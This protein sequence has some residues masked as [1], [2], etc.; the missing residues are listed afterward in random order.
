MDWLYQDLA[1]QD[2]E[3]KN[4]VTWGVYS[5]SGRDLTHDGLSMTACGR[6]LDTRRPSLQVVNVPQPG[7]SEGTDMLAPK[8]GYRP[9][10]ASQLKRRERPLCGTN[11]S[12]GTVVRMSARP[13]NQ[14]SRE[15]I[16]EHPPTSFRGFMPL[17]ISARPRDRAATFDSRVSLQG[18]SETL[19]ERLLFD[20]DGPSR[21]LLCNRRHSDGG[22]TD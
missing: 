15:T 1:A 21:G 3:L 10:A 18:L 14:A 19:C 9:E 11:L 5:Q 13:R 6:T 4:W 2:P 8:G 20:S 22:P 12:F 7:L 16:D 17:R